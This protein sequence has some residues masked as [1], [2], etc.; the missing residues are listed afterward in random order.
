MTRRTNAKIAGFTFLFYIAAGI[1][2]LVLFGQAAS[3]TGITEK[4]AGISAHTTSV[5]ITVLLG[6]L[7]SFSALVLAVTLYA[8][9]REEDQD[10][11]MLGLVCRLGE[12][13]VG[14]SVPTALG[15]LW[16]ARPT[17]VNALDT[18]ATH[19]IGAFLLQV[20]GWT[21]LTS[22]TFFAAGSTFFSWLFL[23]GRMI[24]VALA[25]LGVGASA[26]LVVLLP[27][28]LAG[29]LS[30]PVT[31]FMWL[32]MLAFEVPLALWLLVKG[33]APAARRQSA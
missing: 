21:S 3:G 16:L 29:F 1:T 6:L 15:L 25:W 7:E 5:R 33:V 9:T 31:S 20:G 11:A 13:L 18:A 32:P 23:R 8:I 12:G 17:G 24:P 22:A 4:L 30:G 26:L 14:A 28:Q 27:L 10:L 19:A 2:G